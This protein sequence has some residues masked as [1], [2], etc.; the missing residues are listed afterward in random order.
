[1][2]W[3][4]VILGLVVSIPALESLFRGLAGHG[5]RTWRL[6]ILVLLLIAGA[7]WAGHL[8]FAGWATLITAVFLESVILWSCRGMGRQE[9]GSTPALPPSAISPGAPPIPPDEAGSVQTGASPAEAPLLP[10]K[11]GSQASAATQAPGGEAPSSKEPSGPTETS[12]G[13]PAACVPKPLPPDEPTRAV[14]TCALLAAPCEVTAEVFF[15]SLRRGGLREAELLAG[16]VGDKTIRIR[17]GEIVIELSAE[18]QRLNQAEINYATTQSWDWPEAATVVAKHAAH[19]VLI[20]RAAERI[21]RTEIVRLHRRAQAALAEFA[22]VVAVLWPGAGRLMPAPGHSGPV[23]GEAGDFSPTEICVNFRMFPPAEGQAGPFV[24]DSVGLHVFGLPDVQIPGDRE[25][26]DAVSM[27][28]YRAAEQIFADG[29][30]VKD[31]DWLD[32]GELGRWR[33]SRVR[34]RFEPERGVIELSQGQGEAQPEAPG[35]STPEPPSAG[36]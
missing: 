5:R 18:A 24:S 15:A 16:P 32:L 4:F 3:V 29:C 31:G 2:I 8:T 35:N 1:M 13:E 9:L 12:T 30:D 17:T 28:L 27:V 21:P 20:T 36:L 23:E 11:P 25:P 33:V 34:S 10:I 22:P 14:T 26:D 19:V 6:E 7:W